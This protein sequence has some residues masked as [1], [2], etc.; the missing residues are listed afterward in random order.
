M[1]IILS[2]TIDRTSA[3]FRDGVTPGPDWVEGF[4]ERHKDAIRVR[5]ATQ[6]NRK[7]AEISVA[8]MRAYFDHLYET[9][10]DVPPSNLFNF[11]ETNV[12][13]NTGK[14]KCLFRRG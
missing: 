1:Y 13:D 5:L 14:S 9:T 12:C 6:I 2:S 7:R 3:L 10:K 4:L 8:D 11:D